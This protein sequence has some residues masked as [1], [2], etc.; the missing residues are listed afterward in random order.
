MNRNYTMT[1]W[2]KYRKSKSIFL[3]ILLVL[4]LSCKEEKEPPKIIVAKV[5]N[6]V[7]TVEKLD[8]LLTFSE[9]KNKYREEVIR[10]WID[11]EVLFLEA[12]QEGITQDDYFLDLVENSNKKLAGSLYL[13]K[14]ISEQNFEVSENELLEY[15]SNNSNDFKV[16]VQAYVYNHAVFKDENKAILFR[17]TLIESDW[18]KAVNV[19]SGDE[20]IIFSTSNNFRYVHEI[21]SEKVKIVLDNLE[22]GETSIIF[23]IIP[24]RFN[25]VQLI[26]R[27]EKGDIPDFDFVK[28]NVKQHYLN[29]Q[30]TKS[31]EELLQN[32]YSKY[33]V[34]INR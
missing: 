15:F 8:S 21:N 12:E 32:L 33:D 17:S 24:G 6:S 9:N 19:F 27:Y 34:I 10:D 29:T 1:G 7:L 25:I 23:E 14:F 11:A 22:L 30:K 20:T 28:N 5:G 13:D 4:L 2:R 3:A 16:P 31:Y 18:N 26:A